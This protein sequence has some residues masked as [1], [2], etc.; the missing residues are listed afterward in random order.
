[1]EKNKYF[2]GGAFV[3]LGLAILVP[4]IFAFN[5]L[6]MWNLSLEEVLAGPAFIPLAILFFISIFVFMIGLFRIVR[7]FGKS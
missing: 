3:V 1:M 4:V 2:S 6:G 5:S 7:Q